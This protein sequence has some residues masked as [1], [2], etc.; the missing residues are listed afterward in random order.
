MARASRTLVLLAAAA[1]A[2]GCTVHD[3][4]APSPTGPSELSLSLA[5]AATPDTITQDGSSQA[6]VVV[7]ARD[8]GGRAVANLP[9]RF[10]VMKDG[11]IVDYG[12]L[13]TKS[14]ITGADGRFQA[15]YTAPA[16]PQNSSEIQ[17]STVSVLATPVGTNYAS[18]VPRSVDIRLVPAGQIP[19][20]GTGPVSEFTYAWS[21]AQGAG[22]PVAF[23]ASASSSPAGLVSYVWDFG[24]GTTGSGVGVQHVY[25][26]AGTYLV[27]LTVTDKKGQTA[28][29]TQKVTV[30][31]GPTPLF[32]WTPTSPTHGLPIT[33]DASLSWAMPPAAISTY[34]WD[35]GDGWSGAGVTAFHAYAA[36]GTFT[37]KLTVTDS[38]GLVSRLTQTVVVQ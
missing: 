13:S 31:A 23:D 2:A 30:A 12:T 22:V 17:T 9:L 14:G 10:D 25:V 37:V 1:L 11:L 6:L 8:V 33:F 27:R 36:A 5:V 15:V 16:P 28:W 24:D 4:P 32:T 29:S 35:F 7:V 38:N 20:S 19:P 26:S 18:V 21:G 3:T 34:A